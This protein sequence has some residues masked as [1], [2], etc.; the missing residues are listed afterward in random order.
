[1]THGS[2]GEPP[3]RVLADVDT[4]AEPPVQPPANRTAR[5]NGAAHTGSAGAAGIVDHEHG[6][7]A[8]FLSAG[9]RPHTCS[10]C[11]TPVL[12]KKNSRKHT[13]IQWTMDAAAGCPVFAEQARAGAN[14]AL[15]D[16][17]ESLSASIA[18]AAR[19]GEFGVLDD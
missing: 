12:V 19:Q 1:M 9:L 13:S 18:V 5:H 7:R 16:T 10:S 8:E 2:G 17:C 6:E 11:G 3:A 14:T 15:L 4:C